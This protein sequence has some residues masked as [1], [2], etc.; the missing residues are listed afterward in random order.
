MKFSYSEKEFICEYGKCSRAPLPFKEECIETAR[1][2]S[3]QAKALGRIPVI[4]LSGGL[5]S[6][7]IVRSFMD[8]GV[9]FKLM[10]WRFKDKLNE[11]ELA[12]VRMFCTQHGLETEYF[13]ISPFW[14]NSPEAQKLF[15]DAH[16]TYL[17]FAYN[18]RLM[19]HIWANG[20]FPVLGEEGQLERSGQEW[21]YVEYEYDRALFRHAELHGMQSA[22]FL[23][24][25]V[26]IL[27]SFLTHP[28]MIE[29]ATGKN[30]LANILLTTSTP[31]K[32]QMY[33][34]AWPDLKPR[35]KYT[36][37]ERIQEFVYEN[38][39][40]LNATYGIAENR[41]WVKPYAAFVAS[42]TDK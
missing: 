1:T 7:V 22:G 10:T 23:Q 20:G 12:Y 27:A 39:T 38:T 8:A 9:D 36:G 4:C 19:N 16:T 34:E 11:H 31:I 30:K 40:M 17:P 33:M 21:K 29:L 26:E 18:M 28:L 5:D 37:I 2:I 15:L 6:E 32:Y 3:E 24:H 42:L 14:L 41:T 25:T 13:D 35:K